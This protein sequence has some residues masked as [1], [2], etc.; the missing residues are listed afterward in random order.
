MFTKLGSLILLL[1]FVSFGCQGL[2]PH[3]V[4]RDVT[5]AYDVESRYKLEKFEG[6]FAGLAGKWSEP[7]RAIGSEIQS[8]IKANYGATIGDA[9][10]SLY[11]AQ[12]QNDITAYMT[13]ESPPWV[14][15][16]SSSLDGVDKQLATIDMQQAWLIAEK[17]DLQGL[18]ATQIFNGVAVFADPDCRGSGA[19]TC[20]QIEVTSE[21]LLNAE[22]PIEII[23]TRYEVIDSG[24]ALSLKSNQVNFNYGRLGLYYLTNLI[25][26][27]DPEEGAGLRD[28]ALGAINCRGLAGRLAGEDGVYGVDVLGTTIGVSLNDLIGNCEEG[29]FGTVNRFVDGFSAPM[30]MNLD[31]ESN[32][33]DTNRDGKVDQITGGTVEGDM[34]V[35]L[36]SGQSKESP[37]SGFFDGFRVG[38]N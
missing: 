29:V 14:L 23:S 25:L 33:F 11:G 32:T 20:D 13:E 19:L 31:G 12:L 22:F 38:Q 16:L 17:E 8:T 36:F 34:N 2:T 9:F 5:G 10:V 7:D 24:S 1:S 30:K 3:S 37:V 27:D 6:V 15:N 35:E 26:P 18:E 4:E 28:V 21:S